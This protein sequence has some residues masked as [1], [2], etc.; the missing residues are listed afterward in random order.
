MI[1]YRRIVCNRRHSLFEVL[2]L[3]FTINYQ[4]LYLLTNKRE[5]LSA[6]IITYCTFRSPCYRRLCVPKEATHP[7][8]KFHCTSLE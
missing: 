3:V 4:Y 1:R 2:T 8:S 6:L 7:T 5:T